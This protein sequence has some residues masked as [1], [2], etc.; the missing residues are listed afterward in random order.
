MEDESQED[1]TENIPK[2]KVK[3]IYGRKE[4]IYQIT[5]ANTYPS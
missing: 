5:D 3:T 1:I 4:K 2:I